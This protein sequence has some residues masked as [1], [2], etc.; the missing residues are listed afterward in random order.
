MRKR[1]GFGRGLEFLVGIL[2]LNGGDWW[3]IWVDWRWG[4][5]G[6]EWFLRIENGGFGM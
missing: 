3:R 6:K 1:N 2:R 4:G 5:E